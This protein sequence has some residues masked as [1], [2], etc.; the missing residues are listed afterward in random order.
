[1]KKLIAHIV[2][3]L[4]AFCIIKPSFAFFWVYP[5]DGYPTPDFID[6]ASAILKSGSADCFAGDRSDPAEEKGLAGAPAADE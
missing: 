5:I 3:T 4:I 1:M 6:Q 2:I